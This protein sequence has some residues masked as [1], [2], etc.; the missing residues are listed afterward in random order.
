MRYA[1]LNDGR[2][3]F[4]GAATFL[5]KAVVQ[6]Y[7]RCLLRIA[8]CLRPTSLVKKAASRILQSSA[9]H[10]LLNLCGGRQSSAVHD[11]EP[12]DRESHQLSGQGFRPPLWMQFY[13]HAA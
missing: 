4:P 9:H 7:A 3:G 1:G 6:A 12:G 10:G 2:V 11:E 13:R 8:V 5:P